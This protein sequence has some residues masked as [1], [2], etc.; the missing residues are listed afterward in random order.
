MVLWLIGFGVVSALVIALTRREELTRLEA[1]RG[2]MA[3]PKATR[4]K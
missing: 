4:D 2:I 3:L 1:F